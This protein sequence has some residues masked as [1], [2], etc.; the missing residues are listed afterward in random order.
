MDRLHGIVDIEQ[1]IAAH[2]AIYKA[3]NARSPDDA[4]RRMQAH[5]A[6]ARELLTRPRRKLS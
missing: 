2:K 5:L 4:R 1:P 6:G 3:I